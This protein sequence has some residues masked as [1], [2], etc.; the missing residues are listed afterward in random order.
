MTNSTPTDQELAARIAK[1]GDKARI[2][3][4]TKRHAKGYNTAR[5]NLDTLCSDSYFSEYGQLAVAA[6]R[7][8]REYEELQSETAA[9]GVITGIAS[10]NIKHI[11]VA[12]TKL[13]SANPYSTVLIVN[14]YSVLAG[15]QGYFHHL[16]ID[17]MLHIASKKHLPVIMFTEGGGGRPGDTDISTVNSGL[18]CATFG[19][20]ASL[21]G[22]VPR[23]AVNNGY[24]FAGNAA[25]FGVA[26]ITIATES[27]SIGMAGPAMI[28]GGGLGKFAPAEIGPI[29]VQAKNGVVDIVADNE[30]H[31]IN[32]AKVCLGYF[33]GYAINWEAPKHDALSNVLPQDRRFVYDMYKVINGIVDKES[34]TELC[35]Q[36][37]GA[38]IQGFARI[39]GKPIGLIAN[40]C[41]VLGGA[42][43]VDAAHKLNRFMRLCNQFKIPLVSLTDTPG[44]M[45]GP[46][47]EK[48]G[49]VRHLSELFTT[50]ANLSVDFIAVVIRKCYGLG[51]QA[52]LSGSTSNPS[53]MVSWPQGEFGPMGLEGAIK[54]GFKKEL[55]GEKDAKKRQALFDTLLAQQYAKG[56]ALE[57]ATMLEIDAVINPCDTRKTIANALS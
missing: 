29:N 45:V 56:K 44:F 13:S 16:K 5:E 21:T 31:A 30:N 27:S 26:D 47:H 41:K 35:A 46:E 17:R 54:L 52:M 8:R 22:K 18:Q 14:D 12:N 11:D 10:I 50:G 37:G 55:A 4:A 51:A 25:L 19:H 36:Y 53:Y 57:V 28:E 33:Q 49:A 48:G 42:I 32:L 1:T 20:W 38:I 15:T 24:C 23:I 7:Q 2:S 34:F 40:N 9:D 39:E 3:Q 43:D 6:Q